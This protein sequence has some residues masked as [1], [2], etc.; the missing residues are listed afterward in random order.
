MSRIKKYSKIDQ[1][2]KSV[3]RSDELLFPKHYPLHEFHLYFIKYFYKVFLIRKNELEF[4]IEFVLD[5]NFKKKLKIK[6]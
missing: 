3:L 1:V 5:R 6:N 4:N 2:V